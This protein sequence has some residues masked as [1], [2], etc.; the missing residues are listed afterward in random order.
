MSA[1]FATPSRPLRAAALRRMKRIALAMLACA[2]AGL[3]VS[4]LAV[5]NGGP[6]AWGWLG[7]FCEAAAVGAMADWFAVVALF[8]HPLGLPLPHTAIV[9]VNKAR[10]ADSLAEFVRDHFLEPQALL[11]KLEALD[12]AS[13]LAAWLNDPQRMRAG[14]EAARQWAIAGIDLFDDARMR[15]ATMSL[16]VEQVRTWN[17]AATTAEALTMLT[18]GGR[19]QVLLDAALQKVAGFLA[20]DEVRSR[21]ADLMV[22]HARRE[23]PTVVGLVDKVTPV[24]RIADGLAG[25]LSASILG[26]L[27]DVLMQPE[28]PVRLRYEAW[29]RRFIERLREDPELAESFDRV[30]ARAVDD[31]V[32]RD[33]V[34][35]V[36]SHLKA[37]L[38]ADL[39]EPESAIVRHIEQGLADAGARIASDSA[40][41]ASLNE[42]LLS[43]AGEIAGRLRDGA[44]E[45][46]AQT[47]KA[48]ED[49]QLVEELELAVGKDL[50]FIR[51]NGTLVGGVV[52]LL[53]YALQRGIAGG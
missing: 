26:E 38:R 10:I 15:S 3:A 44:T 46:I 32:V 8:R 33:Y 16:I 6:P 9:T 39:A 29:V 2:V 36:W 5:A 24:A 47:V 7:A 52:G 28:H 34:A 23:W 27:R 31:P 12:P 1:T 4:H 41:R 11:Q 49:E 25:K 53:L 20:E 22:R 42:H 18:Q 45:H 35:S 50:Q 51:L 30:K 37:A 19:H 48:W 21:V 17:A 43:A 14:V 40:L 13:R